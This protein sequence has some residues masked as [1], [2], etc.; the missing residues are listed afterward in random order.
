MP[1][2]SSTLLLGLEEEGL[3]AFGSNSCG[4]LGLGHTDNQ[5]TPT[6]VP[7]NGPKPVQVDWGADYSLVLDVEGGVWEAGRSQTSN[8]F[9]QVSNL[10]PIAFVG[11]GV[12]QCVAV[13]TEGVLWMWTSSRIK[14]DLSWTTKRVKGLPPLIKEIGRAH[15]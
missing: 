13:D 11:A 4:Q 7:W 3:L 9:Q 8:S 1:L 6:Q 5:L 2:G 12:S 14:G 15:V 10:P